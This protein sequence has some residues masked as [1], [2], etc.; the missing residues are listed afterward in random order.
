M[1]DSALFDGGSV[2]LF[3]PRPQKS[4][5][6]AWAMESSSELEYPSSPLSSLPSYRKV[7][8]PSILTP[9][10]GSPV[11]ASPTPR[12][13]VT[14]KPGHQA[15]EFSPGVGRRGGPSFLVSPEAIANQEYAL[16]PEQAKK[17]FSQLKSFA[18][19]DDLDADV[20]KTP[21]GLSA[22]E[23][24]LIKE[25]HE[26][27]KESTPQKDFDAFLARR[28]KAQDFVR[29]LSEEEVTEMYTLGEYLGDGATSSVRVARRVGDEKMVAVKIIDA[30]M[31]YR[32]R[33][34]LREVAI[35][36]NISHPHVIR[37][38]ES[39][40][41]DKHLYL[42]MDLADG[43]PLFDWIV[44]SHHY[45]EKNARDLVKTL[46]E[47]VQYLHSQGIAHRDLKPENIMVNEEDNTVTILD[48][49][50]AGV[51]METEGMTSPGGTPGYKAPDF[52]G[53]QYGK[54]VD[55]WSLG[56]ITYILLCGFPPFFSSGALKETVDYLSN[57]P[58]W[59]FFNQDTDELRNEIKAG[60]VHFPSPF[61]DDISDDA[62]DFVCQLLQIDQSRRLRAEE[63]LTHPWIASASLNRRQ[64]HLFADILVHSSPDLLT[65]SLNQL[66]TIVKDRMLGLKELLEAQLKNRPNIEQLRRSGILRESK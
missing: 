30:K 64:S 32:H 6:V 53:T 29:Q 50:F 3:H 19:T 65:G 5:D 7:S 57:T 42:F 54:A 1:G 58:F 43:E 15:R 21:R 17:R 33:S 63:A 38:R 28:L 56:V 62:K 46:L 34:L 11:S 61:W 13:P 47:T 12:T 48:F 23:V 26:L 27:T 49:G 39:F 66:P 37:L 44:R 31:L 41:T 14:R 40:L 18:S 59:Y 60:K 8:S 22:A 35:L 51:E 55:I 45:G 10:S 24:S 36:S 20:L 9:V 2:Q 4:I 16:T 25:T 52:F